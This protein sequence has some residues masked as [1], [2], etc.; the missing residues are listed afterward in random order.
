MEDN[1]IIMMGEYL[2]YFESMRIERSGNIEHE[3]SLYFLFLK[4][5]NGFLV[6]LFSKRKS[7]CLA[8]KLE[9]PMK[10]IIEVMFREW[11]LSRREFPG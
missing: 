2:E 4:Q 10:A 3:G 8:R 5:G 9:C 1:H 11:I 6:S 7:E